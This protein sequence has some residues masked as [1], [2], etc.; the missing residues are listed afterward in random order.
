MNKLPLLMLTATL[1]AGAPFAQA[2]MSDNS[3]RQ[4]L[5]H[6]ADLDLAGTPGVSVLYGRLRNAAQEVCAP[7]NAKDPER[8][9]AFK[10]CVADAMSSAVTQVDQPALSSYYRAKL[11]GRNAI[12]PQTTA[13]K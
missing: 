1:A 6:Y 2:D 12:P 5:I 3:P 10:H 8:A 11:Q 9:S 7:L 13:R 4:V